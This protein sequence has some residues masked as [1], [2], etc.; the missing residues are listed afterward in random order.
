MV[1]GQLLKLAGITDEQPYKL[2]NQ[3]LGQP[4]GRPSALGAD[5]DSWACTQQARWQASPV[6]PGWAAQLQTRAPTSP[7]FPLHLQELLSPL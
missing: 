3:S 2:M 6:L 1:W 5:P 7:L 4:D